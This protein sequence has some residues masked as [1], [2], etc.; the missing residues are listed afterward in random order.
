MSY[1][2]IKTKLLAIAKGITSL[3]DTYSASTLSF[4]ATTH[5]ISDS[6][7]GLVFV[8]TDDVITIAGSTSNDGTYHVSDGAN[9]GYVVVTEDLTTEDAG[10]AVTLT[11]PTHVTHGDYSLF[12]K[13][14]GN[15]LVLVPGGVSEAT[16]QAHSSIKTWTLYG[17]LF[18]KFTTEAETWD[19]FVSLRSDLIDQM[20][21]YPMLDNSSGILKIRVACPGDPE[22]VFDNQNNG[23]FWFTQRLEISVTERSAL[24]GGDFS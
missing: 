10:D 1:T 19:N 9:A 18:V 3:K 6:A 5:K 4:D 15:F 8:L 12:D 13:G 2:T 7:G 24:S 17:D 16:I 14:V 11:A 21:K 22:G 23:P 20:E